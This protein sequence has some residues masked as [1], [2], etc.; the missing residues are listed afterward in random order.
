MSGK[1]LYYVE[2]LEGFDDRKIQESVENDLAYYKN[3][4]YFA[5]PPTKQHCLWLYFIRNDGYDAD[6]LWRSPASIVEIIEIDK[7]TMRIR[8]RQGIFTICKIKQK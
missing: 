8:T 6:V 5:E 7:N 4:F 1:T 3:Q 2:K